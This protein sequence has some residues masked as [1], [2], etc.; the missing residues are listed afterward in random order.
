MAKSILY[1]LLF[2]FFSFTKAGSKMC[3]PL[4]NVAAINIGYA[5]YTINS[6]RYIP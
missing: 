4:Q 5:T 6:E 3:I 1:K 2:V